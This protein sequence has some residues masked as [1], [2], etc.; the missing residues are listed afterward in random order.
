MRAFVS[1]V[2][3]Y[4]EHHCRY[5]FRLKE[6]HLAK[7]A[8]AMGLL[9]LPKMKEI[10]KAAKNTLE[11]FEECTDIDIDEIPYLDH[12]REK[13]R[14]MQLEKSARRKKVEQKK[15][16]KMLKRKRRIV[17]PKRKKRRNQKRSSPRTNVVK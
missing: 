4:K 14:K 9:R 3:G 13:Q 2:R 17:V 8:N 15:K 12:Q 5:I 16:K 6:L 7:L 10:R 1:Y 11:G